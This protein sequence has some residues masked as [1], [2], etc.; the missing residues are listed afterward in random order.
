[1]RASLSWSIRLMH[2]SDWWKVHSMAKGGFNVVYDSS[3]LMSDW[4]DQ[5]AC[6]SQ[7]LV[8]RRI[9]C[10]FD[11]SIKPN[12][13]FKSRIWGIAQLTYMYVVLYF[14]CNV[15]PYCPQCVHAASNG[16]SKKMLTSM[17]PS[18]AHLWN[19]WLNLLLVY[20]RALTTVH[21]LPN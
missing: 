3:G 6:H 17:L 10:F 21:I 2:W 13:L 4:P 9:Y 16:I 15:L 8:I 12:S 18:L 14:H 5:P 19:V 11:W 20:C 7:C 1:M